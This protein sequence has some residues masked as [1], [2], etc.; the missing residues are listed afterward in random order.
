MTSPA[1]QVQFVWETA[2]ASD[3]EQR[4]QA[5][6]ASGAQVHFEEGRPIVEV[7]VGVMALVALVNLILDLQ[8]RMTRHGIIINASDP[9][10]IQVKE[11]PGLE[12]GM[13]VTVDQHGNTGEFD[14][15][16][17]PAGLETILKALVP[18]G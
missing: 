1:D 13:V 7:I 18:G 5:L 3:V 16:K 15:R 2:V 10:N 6:E 14:Q 17:N 12:Y 4:V 11:E 8:R 9:T